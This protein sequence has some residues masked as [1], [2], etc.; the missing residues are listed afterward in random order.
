MSDDD[1]ALLEVRGLTKSFGGVRAVDAVDLTLAA[2]E[3][4]A[5]IGPNGCG[6]TTLFNL[7]T[8]Q[9][10][11][12][13]GSVRIGGLEVAGLA[14][15]RIARQGVGRKFQVPSVY[16]ELTVAENLAIA[17]LAAPKTRR[18]AAD[19]LLERVGL[20]DR[21]DW[22]AGSLSHGQKQWLEIAMVLATRPRLVLLDE[23]TAGMTRAETLATI[24][25][26]RRLRDEE[27]VA[28]IVIE[29]DMAAVAALG[30]RVAAMI[31]GRVVVEGSFDTVRAHPAVIEAYLGTTA[32]GTP[33]A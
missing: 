9:L 1:R 15:D 19:G 16:D 23:P 7:L 26:V 24:D 13:T 8:G 10:R 17:R 3:L 31:S 5:V 12:D 30:G 2:G 32:T 22:S 29:H 20:A 6:K 27:G 28:T 21:T 14:P 33:H 25:L 11:P 18:S 4:L